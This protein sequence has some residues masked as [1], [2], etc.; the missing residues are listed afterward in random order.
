MKLVDYSLRDFSE[1]LASDM[2]APGG[3]SAAALS[4]ALGAALLCMTASLTIGRARYAEHEPF[5]KEALGIAE[6]LRLR[7]LDI[8]DRDNE[9]FKMVS[10]VYAM[11]K[12]SEAESLVRNAAMQDALKACALIPFELMECSLRALE[13]A[14]EMVG[15]VNINAVSDLGVAVLNLKASAQGAWL[16]VLINLEGIR[17]EIFSARYTISGNELMRAVSELSDNL[18]NEILR[19]LL[20]K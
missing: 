1:I 4:G 10:A 3:G 19:G 15:R 18:Y 16:N 2:P 17:D 13:L 7:M 9:A 8:L 11:P 5:V 12:D 14:D 20:P 6:E